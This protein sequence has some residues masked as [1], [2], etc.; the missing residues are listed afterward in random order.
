[1]E[2]NIF[3]DPNQVPQPKDKIKIER[4]EATPYPDRYRVHVEIDVTPFRERPNLLI[5]MKDASDSIINEL[6]VIETMHAKME[7]TLHIRGKDDPA[8][9]Y[10]I[11]VEL[12][13]E[14]RNPPQDRASVSLTIPSADE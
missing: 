4:V 3:N 8:G 14:T 12:F 7:F 10:L 1:M 6:S 11:D 5:V 2:I 9:D 13:F